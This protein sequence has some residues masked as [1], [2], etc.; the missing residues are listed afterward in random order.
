MTESD[1][2]G[3]LSE[4]AAAGKAFGDVTGDGNYFAGEEKDAVFGGEEGRYGVL[5]EGARESDGA[6]DHP[7]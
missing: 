5:F 7:G 2:A 3:W 6:A 4:N 1:A